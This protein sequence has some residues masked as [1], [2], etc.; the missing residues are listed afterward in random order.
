M[1]LSIIESITGT[2]PN[3]SKLFCLFTNQRLLT[4]QASLQNDNGALFCFG[5][6]QLM[7]YMI[8]VISIKMVRVCYLVRGRSITNN[9][10]EDSIANITQPE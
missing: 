4:L 9:T 6:L 7:N 3:Q 5:T 8:F 10:Q 2:R 1:Y